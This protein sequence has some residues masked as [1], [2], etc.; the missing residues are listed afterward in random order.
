MSTK[1]ERIIEAGVVADLLGETDTNAR[2]I[3]TTIA[4]RRGRKFLHRI[5][6]RAQAI[7]RGEV[8]DKSARLRKDGKKRTIGGTW[9]VLVKRKMNKAERAQV[10]P[11][12]VHTC[13]PPPD[14]QAA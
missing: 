14:V 5:L 3:I 4:L 7:H 8:D 9:F 12:P 13:P 6:S 1:A 2:E 10:W 11:A